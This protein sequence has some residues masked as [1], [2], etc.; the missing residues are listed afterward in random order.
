MVKRTGRVGPQPTRRGGRS[1]AAAGGALFSTRPAMGLLDVVRRAPRLRRAAG[2][3]A[4]ATYATPVPL[5]AGRWELPRLLNRRRL[6]GL[7][8]EIGVRDG[9]FSRLLPRTRQG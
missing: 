9:G 1:A 7:A 6:T 2:V 3:A 4:R 5:L 8:L